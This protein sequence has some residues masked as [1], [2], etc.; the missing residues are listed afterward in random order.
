MLHSSGTR[1]GGRWSIQEQKCH[2]NE[3]EIKAVQ[4]GLHALCHNMCDTHIL[5]QSHNS[6]TLANLNHTGGCKS[7][8]CNQI[9]K[10]IWLWCKNKQLWLTA[11]HIPGIENL[12]ADHESRNFNDRTEW[13]LNPKIFSIITTKL[14]NPTKD[15]FASRLSKQLNRYVSWRPETGATFVDAFTC[16][17]SCDFN[18]ICSLLS[19]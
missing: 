13:Q 16:D 3:L 19:A 6:T 15:M 10:E 8:T 4:F 18:Y 12:E 9:A 5:I 7:T 14:G 1:T 2:I 17:W 11:S